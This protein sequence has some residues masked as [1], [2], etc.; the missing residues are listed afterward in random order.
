MKTKIF[1]TVSR[2]ALHSDPQARDTYLRVL[3]ELETHVSIKLITTIKKDHYPKELKHLKM[4][5][6]TADGKYRYVNDRG[7]KRAIFE[8]DGVI[9]EAS[10]QSFRLGFEAMY[11]LSQ[12]KPV[13]VLSKFRDYSKL[14]DQP[15]FFG[16]KYTEFT[17][18]DE[19]DKFLKH[20]EKH[21]L[22]NRFNLFI[23]DEHKKHLE[24]KAKFYGVSMSEY[25]RK[26]IEED[27]NNKNL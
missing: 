7:V 5:L 12:N 23:S 2:S 11:A 18:P 6:T 19:I 1:F 4:D 21:R 14:I 27:K 16:A 3:K 17:L 20:V 15:N 9:I 22:R 10:Y 25:V 24:K 8:A 13:L 26:L